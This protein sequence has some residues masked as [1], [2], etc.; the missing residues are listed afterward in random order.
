MR[1]EDSADGVK[2]VFDIIET[3][4]LFTTTWSVFDC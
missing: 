1:V 4:F 2:V 3:V